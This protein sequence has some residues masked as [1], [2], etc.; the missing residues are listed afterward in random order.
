MTNIFDLVI[1][2]SS[3]LEERMNQL[4]A[5]YANLESY[6]QSE[7]VSGVRTIESMEARLE[8]PESKAREVLVDELQ[9]LITKKKRKSARVKAKKRAA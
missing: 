1:K 2:L 6:I 4:E 8:Y 7:F 9:K 5:Q 3:I